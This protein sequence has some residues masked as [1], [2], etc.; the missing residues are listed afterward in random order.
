MNEKPFSGR[1]TAVA[2]VLLAVA[3]AVVSG[4]TY[5]NMRHPAPVIDQVIPAPGFSKTML[6]D[7]FPGIKGTAADT[8]V[9]IQEGEESGG[10]ALVLGGTHPNE[11]AACVAAL[12]LLENMKIS[13]GRV[14]IIPFANA[15]ARTHTY[16]QDGQPGYFSI[17]RPN[18]KKRTFRYGARISNPVWEWPN[19]D[20]YIHPESGQAM[21]GIERSNLNRAYPGSPDGS[22]TEQLA[23]AIISVIRK[24]NVDL[25]FDLHE[26]SPEYPVVNA[27]VAH[28]RAMEL[29][30]MMTMELEALGL[31][32][33]LEPSP[34]KLRG[35]SHREWGDH[36][37]VLALLMET[38]NPSMGRFRGKTGESLILDGR[39][40][41]YAKAAELKQIY[42]PYEQG[43]QPMDLRVG[44]HVAAIREALALLDMVKDGKTI[45][46]SGIPEFHEVME[47]GT[48]AFLK[49]PAS[50]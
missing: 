46:C 42:I 15:M 28:D 32:Y 35:L 49:D 43:D 3:A 34:K 1:T 7:Y 10:T 33:R 44:R 13:Q 11:P 50:S 31:S 12:V 17:E 21:A 47:K 26:A 27:I 22:M 8:G 40:K 5:W 18:G 45:V 30:A 4:Q 6:S 24:E 38:G 23:Y 41:A 19:P 14:I 39:D 16:P 25:A 9:Y 2:V 48:G 37:D 29:A 20:I 36:T